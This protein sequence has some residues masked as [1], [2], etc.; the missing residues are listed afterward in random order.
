MADYYSTSFG[1]FS[2]SI[3]AEIRREVWGR[4]IG[5]HSW[6]TA[7]RQEEF[8]KRAGYTRDTRLLEIG[9]GSGG[10]AL[11][12]C[13]SIGL[14]VTGIDSNK[15]GIAAANAE[16]AR[17]AFSARAA[18]LCADGAGALPFAD[19]A[20]DAIACIDAIN[21]LPD[22]ARVLAEWRRVLKPGGTLL[23]TD[24]VVVTG[25]VTAEEFALR[26]AIGFFVFVPPGK[27]EQLLGEAGFDLL[28]VEDTTEDEAMISHRRVTAREKRRDALIEI[29]GAETFASTQTFLSTVHALSSSRRLSRVMYLARKP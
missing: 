9:C 28:G 29:E 7:E 15:S 1:D 22:R 3:L 5:Q 8:A 16:A 12:L 27:N 23:F 4:D 13:E 18:F 24:P 17:R 20:F 25:P 11:F 10:P 14:T 21:H 19:G 2:A 26:S 6:L